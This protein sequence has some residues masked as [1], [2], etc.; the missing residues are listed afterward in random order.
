MPIGI[1][2]D[3]K[4]VTNCEITP[5]RLLKFVNRGD[6][7]GFLL[8]AVVAGFLVLGLRGEGGRWTWLSLGISLMRFSGAVEGL[9]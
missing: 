6:F 7:V 4:I 8:F 1:F 2:C 9:H 3:A 5:P